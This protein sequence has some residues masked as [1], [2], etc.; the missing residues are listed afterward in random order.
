MKKRTDKNQQS[1]AD[2]KQ[3]MTCYRLLL[4]QLG[5][6]RVSNLKEEPYIPWKRLINKPT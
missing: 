4:N 3:K 1:Q 5:I 6:A 2:Y